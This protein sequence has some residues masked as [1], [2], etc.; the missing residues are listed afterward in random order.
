MHWGD[1]SHVNRYEQFCNRVQ[2]NIEAVP[3]ETIDKIIESMNG[4]L[5]Q[6][7]DQNGERLNYVFKD[8]FSLTRQANV[9]N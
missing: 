3:V 6:I 5:R 8:I 9:F 1:L 4:R 2:Q 7:I